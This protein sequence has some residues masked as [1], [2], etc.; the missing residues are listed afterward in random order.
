[1]VHA[2]LLNR[3][4]RA[5]KQAD[6]LP[7]EHGFTLIELLTVMAI[8]A[9]ITAIAAPS[10]VGASGD[11]SLIDAGNRVTADLNLARQE[12][13]SNNQ[14]VQVRFYQD[15]KNSLYDTVA[16]VIPLTST[17]AQWLDRPVTLP[18]GTAFYTTGNTYSPLITAAPASTTGSPY[19]V[20]ADSD[21][22]TPA[23]LQSAPY[24]YFDFR[25]D[26][27]TDIGSQAAVSAWCATIYP[28]NKGT[29]TAPVNYVTVLVDPTTG[30]IRTYQPK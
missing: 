11:L 27:S 16:H 4:A 26:G 12:A 29:S 8:I 14:T 15:P 30:A 2:Q 25:A 18:Q 21:P 6:R 3:R 9:I 23:R 28:S 22:A 13:M 5:I 20:S 7:T 10:F 24:V 17:T 19:S 1:M